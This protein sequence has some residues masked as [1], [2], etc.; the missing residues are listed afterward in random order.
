[1]KKILLFILLILNTL[2]ANDLKIEISHLK[3]HKG[4][5]LIALFDKKDSFPMPDVVYKKDIIHKIDKNVIEYTFK[6]LPTGTYAVTIVHDENANGK[7]DR[8]FFGMPKE[9]YGLWRNQKVRLG[10]PTFKKS[11]FY[12]DKTT[13][14]KIKMKYI[15]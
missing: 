5:I 10:P 4:E 1:M 14:V 9:G 6:N 11:K 15:I 12:F 3:S 7:M 13:T 2:V 8:F